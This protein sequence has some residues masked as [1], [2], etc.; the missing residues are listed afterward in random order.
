MLHCYTIIV[1]VLE[2]VAADFYFTMKTSTN[3]ICIRQFENIYVLVMVYVCTG[4]QCMYKHT[5]AVYIS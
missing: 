4:V 2:Y 1:E 3:K 5:F